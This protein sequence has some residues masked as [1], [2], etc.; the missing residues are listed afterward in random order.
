MLTMLHIVEVMTPFGGVPVKLLRLAEAVDPERGRLVF[1][2]FQPAALDEVVSRLGSPVRQVGSVSPVRIVRALDRAI[3]EERPDVVCSHHT[4]GLITG[5]LAA[6]RHGLPLIH[7]EHSSAHYRQGIGRLAAQA[8]M[9]R[10]DRVICNSLY[11]L[12]TIQAAYPGI[13]GR[14]CHLHDPVVERLATTPAHAIRTELGLSETDLVIGHI[15]GL[16]PERD[17][18]SLILAIDLLRRSNPHVKLVLVGDGPERA[19]L[20]ALVR[21]RHLEALVRFAGYRDPGDLLGVMDLYVNPC[22]DEGFG[23]AVVEAMLA[24]LPVVIAEAGSH[25]ELIV[26][27]ECGLL[28]E[29]GNAVDLA[30]RLQW[31]IDRPADA[32]GMGARARLHAQREF[33]TGRFMTGYLN[34]MQPVACDLE[35][36]L[37]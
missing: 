15:G 5:Y 4:R 29:P 11:T 10:V 12:R 2:V 6:K 28:Y 13:A 37:Q 18:S 31:L 34:L 1:I 21:T 17:Q 32:R 24:G 33:A 20:E 25:P 30:A 27:G 8:I 26:D 16:I 19:R 3:E 36:R 35:P 14:L 7:H 9:P 22:V 23:I